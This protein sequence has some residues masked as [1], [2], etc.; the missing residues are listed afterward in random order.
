MDRRVVMGFWLSIL[1]TALVW[2]SWSK[3]P[4]DQG[5]SA[6]PGT[7][8][9]AGSTD[10]EPRSKEGRDSAIEFD[11][12]DLP[13][14]DRAPFALDEHVDHDHVPLED[15]TGDIELYQRQ[16]MSAVP[17]HVVRGWGARGAGKVP[18]FVGAVVIVEP[19]ISDESLTQLAKDIRRYHQDAE[20]VSVRVLDEE[21]AATYDRHSDGG[22]LIARHLV[23]LVNI[24]ERLGMDRIKVR[25]QIVEILD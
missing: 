20:A 7:I 3:H 6:P 17:H 2:W 23:A 12:A 10:L 5:I 9:S 19:G 15:P 24:N 16:P 11:V 25:G 8:S 1:M 4:P 14:I 13:D 22:A 18:G 21:R